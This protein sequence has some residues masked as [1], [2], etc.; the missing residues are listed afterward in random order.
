M[1]F[2]LLS[3]SY[4]IT[5]AWR[6]NTEFFPLT[7]L[8]RKAEGC[9]VTSEGIFGSLPPGTA[10]VMMRKEQNPGQE[11]S[12]QTWDHHEHSCDSILTLHSCVRCFS[13]WWT[14]SLIVPEMCLWLIYT[15]TLQI[16]Q[17]PGACI[18]Q[19]ALSALQMLCGRAEALLSI[20]LCCH[21]CTRGV[22]APP[23]E[24]LQ[25]RAEQR[26]RCQRCSEMHCAAPVPPSAALG[27]LLPGIW[28]ENRIPASCLRR[29][30]VCEGTKAL[31]VGKE[32]ISFQ[33][34]D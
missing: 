33:N 26:Y 27:A 1:S 9:G 23:W 24:A 30:L 10:L 2:L 13:G 28:E 8:C 20:A 15:P 19:C 14:W 17:W 31:S 12:T 18:P 11:T 4:Q 32:G 34:K 16:A 5:P 29:E 25:T 3:K 7:S 22:P 21:G 6:V